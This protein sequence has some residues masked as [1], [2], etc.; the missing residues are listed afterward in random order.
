MNHNR[1]NKFE[2]KLL[3]SS[4]SAEE[5]IIPPESKTKNTTRLIDPEV[6]DEHEQMLYAK[7]CRKENV[8]TPAQAAPLRCRYFHGKSAFSKIAPFKTEEASLKPYIV[9]YHNVLFDTEIELIKT[10]ALARVRRCVEEC[11]LYNEKSFNL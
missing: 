9:V 3:E 5:I 7:L 10:M 2:S 1:R 11:T 8:P 6:F 4:E